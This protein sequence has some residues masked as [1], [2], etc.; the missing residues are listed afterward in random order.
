MPVVNLS[1]PLRR[2]FEPLLDVV[3]PPRCLGCEGL[4]HAQDVLCA[5][6]MTDLIRIPFDPDSSTQH[7]ESL[8]H[9]FAATLMHV[10]FDYERE[11]V[12]ES[13]VHAMKY[14]GLY[15]IAEW[16][17]GLLGESCTGT[18]FIS[19][20]P[21]IAP[22]PLHPVK[23]IERGYNQAEHIGRGLARETGL[24][25]I[26]DLLRRTRYTASQAMS[27][28]DILGR[29]ENMLNAFILNPD[30]ADAIS[31]RPVVLVDDLITTGATM[32]ECATVLREHGAVD[33]RFAAIARPI[34]I[35]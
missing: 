11:S 1:R 32:A 26:P 31:S 19:G 33:I 30:H 8:S 23:R 2:L 27:R 6:C 25:C 16:F 12:L 35:A 24:R 3:Y 22:V 17:G 14:R 20:D 5:R 4:I 10:G 29:R 21:I 7:L 13:C 15:R 34:R 9:P 18:P 28:L